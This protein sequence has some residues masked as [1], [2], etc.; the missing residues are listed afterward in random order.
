MTHAALNHR[1]TEAV[2]QTLEGMEKRLQEQVAKV[3]GLHAAVSTL[4]L[5]VAGLETTIA[6]LRAAST[7]SGPT[8]R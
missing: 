1:N 3:D 8:V 7:G 2:R 4:L 5:R 6:L